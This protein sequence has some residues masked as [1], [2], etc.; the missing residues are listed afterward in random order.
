MIFVTGPLFAGKEE[1]ICRHLGWSRAEFAA[2]CLRAV[3]E[4]A[5]NCEDLPALRQLLRSSR[6]P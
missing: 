3:Q 1:A 6:R 5:A 2:C 4:L